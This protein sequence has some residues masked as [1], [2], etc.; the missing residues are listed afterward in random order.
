MAKRGAAKSGSASFLAPPE[1]PTSTSEISAIDQSLPIF[2]APGTATKF[3]SAPLKQK[4]D[5]AG[6]PKVRLDLSAPLQAV[7]GAVGDFGDTVLFFKLY[8]VAPDGD[9]T[10]RH[11]LIAPA[12]IPV[13]DE[14]VDVEL[15]GIVHRFNKGHRVQLVISGSDLAY[16]GN[17]L[18][19]P[20]TIKTRGG[21]PS[22]LTLPVTSAK[23]A[24]SA[25]RR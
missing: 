22:F 18:P 15:P 16:R 6:I 20:V 3:T 5:V 4:L 19:Q 14:H 7:T 12:R 11:R 24:G 1:I 8:D 10:L 21:D 2:D 13:T 23:R 17:V 25:L 9:V